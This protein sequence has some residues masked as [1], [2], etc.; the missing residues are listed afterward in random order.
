[1]KLGMMHGKGLMMVPIAQYT[2]MT[3]GAQPMVKRVKPGFSIPYKINNVN[4]EKS[5]I[6]QYFA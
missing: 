4:F 2:E 5:L 3:D 1:M 6:C